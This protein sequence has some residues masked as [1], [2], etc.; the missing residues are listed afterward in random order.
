MVCLESVV[1][2]E[3]ERWPKGGLFREVIYIER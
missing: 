3:M 2:L 1:C